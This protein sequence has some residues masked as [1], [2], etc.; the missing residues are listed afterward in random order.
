[1]NMFSR[2]NVD[3][4]Q[5]LPNQSEDSSEL[6]IYDD[7]ESR[8]E[9]QEDA[10]GGPNRCPDFLSFLPSLSLTERLLGCATC[11]VCGYLLSFGSFIRMRD[12][13][14]G[15][16]VP[17]V[18]NVTVGNIIALCGT[19]FLTGPQQQLRRMFH[20]TRKVASVAYLGSL[21][22]T[23]F[24]VILPHFRGKGFLLFVLLIFQYV[25]ITWY[26]ITVVESTSKESV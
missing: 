15:N 8:A 24:L 17:L 14:G 23:L 7:E 12:L 13:L 20:E 2:I 6:G 1:M 5:L 11:M 26:V 16:P 21:V 3:Y 9:R 10:E 22:L 19:C 4:R 18:V 25:A